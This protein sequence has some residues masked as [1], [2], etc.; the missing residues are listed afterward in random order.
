MA[1]EANIV[2]LL[3]WP[4]G[5][6]TEA[7]CAAGT[8]ISKGTFLVWSDPKTVTASSAINQSFA[9]IA[10]MDKDA[11][12][13]STKI[14]MYTNLIVDAVSVG[15][16]VNLP[17]VGYPVELSGA[18]LVRLTPITLSTGPSG[19]QFVSG[20]A[21]MVGKALETASASERIEVRIRV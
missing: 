18:N 9:G 3:G 5:E 2:E 10:A 15:G 12:D 17:L 4:P 14:S 19:S 1:N 6:P 11:G 7:T 16:T 21:F 20:A 13:P 8:A